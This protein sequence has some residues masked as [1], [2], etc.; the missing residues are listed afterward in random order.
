MIFAY[1]RICTCE[2]LSGHGW[3]HV[4]WE[5]SRILFLK[6]WTYWLSIEHNAAKVVH[7]RIPCRPK[8][9]CFRKFGS[10]IMLRK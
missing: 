5:S 4:R 10:T 1:D 6:D 3:V 8:P 9:L 7:Y 2:L